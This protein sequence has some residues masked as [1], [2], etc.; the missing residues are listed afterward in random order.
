MEYHKTK[1]IL[2]VQQILGHRNIASTLVYT[3]LI[4]FESDEYTM[5]VANS[6]E[7]ALELGKAG[8]EEWSDY[9]GVK[10]YRKRK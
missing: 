4:R 8:F 1:D 9:K 5:R 2:H 3:H 6:L 7:E 10:I